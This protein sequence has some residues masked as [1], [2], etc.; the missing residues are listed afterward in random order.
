MYNEQQKAIAAYHLARAGMNIAGAVKSLREE[1]ETFRKIGENTLRGWLTEPEFSTTVAA[2]TKVLAEE[3]ERG[4]RE[5]ER[6]AF[7]RK[8]SG[9]R[10]D[11]LN[12]MEE[13]SW[14]LFERLKEKFQDDNTP[15]KDLFEFWKQAHSFTMAL[16][17][18]H[19]AVLTE[20]WQTEI[21]VQ[22]FVQEI[23]AA[24][25]VGAAEGMIKKVNETYAANVAAH[26]QKLADAQGE[27]ADGQ[28]NPGS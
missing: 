20:A 6:S 19:G 15:K 1:E 22:A 17:A 14:A 21:L 12:Q 4:I 3:A 13:E 8:L 24:Y 23:T 7:Q 28:K 26:K 10:L 2:Y 18:K 16:R 11:R 25:G 9:S 5:Q 27:S